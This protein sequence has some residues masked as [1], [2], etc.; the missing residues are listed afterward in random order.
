MTQAPT[1]PPAA[2]DSSAP[3]GLEGITAGDTT[4][5]RV[6]GV[7]GK[8]FYCGYPIEP[9]AEEG[10][11]EE[12]VYLLWNGELPNAAQLESFTA[13]L[14]R[15]STVPSEIWDVLRPLVKGS[16]QMDLLRTA[17]S[18][19]SAFDDEVADTREAIDGR[20]EIERRI[21][22]RLQARISTLVAGIYRLKQGQKPIAARDDLTYAANFLYMVTGEEPGEYEERIFDAALTLHADHGFNASTFSARVTAA[23]E[24]D[25]YGAITSA[26]GTLAGR[27]HGGANMRVMRMLEKVGEVDKA[28]AF[29]DDVL[30]QPKGRVMGFGHRVYKV[31]DPRATVLRRMAKEL[32]DRTGNSKWFDMSVKI[33]NRVKDKKGI[34]PNV[35]FYSA[36]VYGSLELDPEIFTPIFAVSRTSGW[37]AHVLEQH[38]DNRLIR[39]RANYVG[40]GERDYVAK[41]D[42]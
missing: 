15:E 11:F 23:T 6:D 5:S 31:E 3:K 37:L 4:K 17:V 30:S 22:N 1:T 25:I 27:L 10:S 38:A 20:D 26:I 14:R 13:D 35:D 2:S 32:T 12:C 28:E 24:A 33:E 36:S 39:P 21:A 16:T 41:A 18:A 9:L 19:M 42:R 34:F 40:H 8:L 7:N 29:V